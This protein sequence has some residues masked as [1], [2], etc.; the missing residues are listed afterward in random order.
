MAL[1]RVALGTAFSAL[2]CGSAAVAGIPE[3]A[4]AA[5][6]SLVEGAPLDGDDE[7][8]AGSSASGGCALSALQKMRS[9]RSAVDAA[10]TAG[11]GAA[12][13]AGAGLRG[14]EALGESEEVVGNSTL[15][16]NSTGY[17]MTLYHQ[18][19][20][21][22]GQRIIKS[23][24]H[25]GHVGWCGAGIYFAMS[26]GA[27]YGKAKGPNSHLGFIIEAKVNVGRV[28]HMHGWYCTTSP[29]CHRPYH[30]CQDRKN[31]GPAFKRMG[32]DS[33]MFNP[34]DGTEVVI[35]DS[36]RVLSMRHY[37]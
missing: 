37:R 21:H 15:E 34:G 10:A 3:S 31:Q 9:A 27:T 6:P 2:L 20:A 13:G 36:H 29:N 1:V 33:I 17:I 11:E 26:P 19:S 14:G 22:N 30:N 32:Y 28:K 23:N 35:W 7:C 4:V 8:A 18:T 5:E 16:D 12:A 24:F 25:M